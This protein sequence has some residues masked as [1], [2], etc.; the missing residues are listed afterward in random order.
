MISANAKTIFECSWEICNKCGGIY[1]VISSKAVHMLH[2]YSNYYAIGPYFKHK[3][4]Q[5]FKEEEPPRVLKE[6]FYELSSETG[7]VCHY[8]SWLIAG[9]PRTILIEFDS[10]KYKINYLKKYFWEKFKVDSLYCAWDFEEPMLW[11]YAAGLLIDKYQ[12]KTGKQK[13]IGHFH[14]W[15][16]GFGMLHL[17]VVNPLVKSV[18]TTHATMLG[19]SL[20]YHGKDIYSE[21]KNINPEEEAR[22]INVIDKF[23]MER[24]CAQS[25]DIFTTVSEITGKEAEKILGRK[26]EVLTLN[27]FNVD[28]FPTIEET[29]IM[30][31]KSRKK[32]KEYITYHFFPYYHID[33]NNTIIFS[34]YGRPE[35][36][37]KG[38][39]TFIGALG[40]LNR[41]LKQD[42]KNK[43]TIIAFFWPLQGNNGPKLELIQDKNNFKHIKEHIEENASKIFD[44]ILYDVMYGRPIKVDTSLSRKFLLNMRNSR[45]SSKRKGNPLICSYNLD[46][47]QNNEIIKLFLEEGLNNSKENPVKVILYPTDLNNNNTLIELDLY[48]SIS[49]C[50]LTVLPSYYEP[51]GYTPLE[52]SAVGVPTITSNLA[53]FGKFIE[54]RID[55]NKLKGIFV[56]DRYQKSAQEAT[57]KLFQIMKYFCSLKHHERVQSKVKAK[58]LSFYADWKI[59]IENYIKAHNL[60]LEK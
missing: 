57:E 47:E 7:I 30:H 50:H 26:P 43:K 36:R 10:I 16:S 24:A 15:L 6:I 59:L 35:I 11:S 19:R 2:Y 1:T 13:I 9:E 3:A 20:A 42:H 5:E 45:F 33:I 54:K 34:T 29:S 18:F 31:I 51:W 38:M 39:D 48:E 27:G 53:G 25:A 21:L 23:S 41:E 58:E 32:L 60:A 40:K 14:E 56:L 52:S 46:D 4:Q 37:N 49:G 17:K 28:E 44:D 22:K 12:K 55:D 8:G